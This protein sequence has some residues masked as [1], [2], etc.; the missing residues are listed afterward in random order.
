LDIELEKL[1]TGFGM[2]IVA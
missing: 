1:L 2:E